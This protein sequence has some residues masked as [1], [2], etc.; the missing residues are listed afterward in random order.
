MSPTYRI[1]ATGDVREVYEVEAPDEAAALA[2]FKR[3]DVDNPVVSEAS[4]D[5]DTIERI[6]P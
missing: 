4:T 6:E 3:G 1:V 5:A 2:A